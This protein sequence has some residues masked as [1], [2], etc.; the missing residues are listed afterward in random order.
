MCEELRTWCNCYVFR[1]LTLFADIE[2]E[3]QGL[4]TPSLDF[5]KEMVPAGF[6]P[7]TFRYTD[8][9]INGVGLCEANALISGGGSTAWLTKKCSRLARIELA[10]L[11]LA[12]LGL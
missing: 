1:V 7:A 3:S 2:H 10:T 6:E 5:R 4:T 11:G 9:L 12:T 8:F